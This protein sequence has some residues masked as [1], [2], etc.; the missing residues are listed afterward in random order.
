MASLLRNVVRSIGQPARRMKFAP[1]YTLT[2]RHKSDWT[3]EFDGVVQKPLDDPDG[4]YQ[5]K[6]PGDDF[7]PELPITPPGAE[8]VDEGWKDDGTGF[9]G[10]YPNWKEWKYEH[11]DPRPAEPYFVRQDKRYFGEPVHLNDDILN[12]WMPNDGS[13]DPELTTGRMLRDLSVAVG[14]VTALICYDVYIYDAPSRAPAIPTQYPY[15]SLWLERGGDPAITNPTPEQIAA[16]P[17][18]DQAMHSF[19]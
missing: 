8:W 3:D 12:V 4:L 13:A 5:S 19:E 11:R 9:H 18:I 6:Y 7:K 2:A 10:A 17:A 14:L 1:I 16:L 15:N